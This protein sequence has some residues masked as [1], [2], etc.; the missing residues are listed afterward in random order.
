MC[1]SSKKITHF[2]CELRL[3]LLRKKK[4]DIHI[5]RLSVLS[6]FFKTPPNGPA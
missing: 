6:K 2:I 3:H 4:K 1:K 5:T